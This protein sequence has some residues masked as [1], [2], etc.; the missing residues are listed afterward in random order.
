MVQSF[1]VAL[2]SAASA[3]STIFTL[4]YSGALK[5]HTTDPIRAVVK[6]CDYK[7]QKEKVMEALSQ[8]RALKE[9]ELQFVNKAVRKTLHEI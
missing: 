2:R 1:N 6:N 4:S 7:T 8:F 9:E 5:Y 3:L